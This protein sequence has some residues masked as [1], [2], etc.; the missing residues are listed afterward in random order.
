MSLESDVRNVIPALRVTQYYCTNL[1]PCGLY[2]FERF[3]VPGKPA[4][5]DCQGLLYSVS[6]GAVA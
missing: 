6:Y 5:S 2:G 3:L 4:G 1:F